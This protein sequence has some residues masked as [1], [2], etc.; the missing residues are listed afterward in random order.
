[1]G[2]FLLKLSEENIVNYIYDVWVGNDLLNRA[3][4]N[5]AHKILFWHCKGKL[6]GKKVF[7]TH[8]EGLIFKILN[9]LLQT[10]RWQGNLKMGQGVEWHFIKEDTTMA[11]KNLNRGQLN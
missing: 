2:V 7:I 11:S 1:M 9:E 3:Q 4:S 5:N 8:I 10:K 6:H